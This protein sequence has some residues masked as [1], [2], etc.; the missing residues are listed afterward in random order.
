MGYPELY[1]RY[2]KGTFVAKDE[3]WIVDDA[4]LIFNKE[5][6][7]IV[8]E[9]RAEGINIEY[10][11]VVEP[12]GTIDAE[13]NIID[14]QHQ[15][16][17]DDEYIHSITIGAKDEDLQSNDVFS[18]YSMHPNLSGALAYAVCVQ[19]KIDELEA[20]KGRLGDGLDQKYKAAY[21]TVLEHNKEA[22]EAYSRQ[23]KDASAS[24][25]TASDG[26]TSMPVALQDICGDGT[27]E[28]IFVTAGADDAAVLH[29][30]TYKDGG[31][32]EIYS[33]DVDSA[34]ERT[35]SDKTDGAP[36][37]LL[38]STKFTRELYLFCGSTDPLGKASYK[39]LSL[40]DDKL[41]AKPVISYETI[42]EESEDTDDI[43]D[44][45]DKDESGESGEKEG[46]DKSEQPGEKGKKKDKITTNYK[47][48]D[49]DISKKDYGKVEKKLLFAAKDIVLSDD[50]YSEYMTK[51]DSF[52]PSGN[53]SM[54][55]DE[56]VRKLK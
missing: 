37:Y 9:C 29:I 47:Y 40:E 51:G 46:S 43:D 26:N 41:V 45:D 3:A 15:A 42:E 13:G 54:T 18:S 17:S 44:S 14:P 20:A 28:L 25:S 8:K 36:G 32:V 50:E 56:A 24:Q 53:V 35:G 52:D 21:L 10:V 19:K 11:S 12:F 4:V 55:Y 7:S 2:G 23:F 38:F 27:P 31:A 22:I 1:D 33:C 30:F 49:S 48:K 34:V 39:K 5:I 6:E 16:Y